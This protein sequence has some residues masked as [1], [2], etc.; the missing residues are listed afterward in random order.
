MIHS[1]PDYLSTALE[2]PPLPKP[3]VSIPSGSVCAMT[4]VRITSGYPISAVTTDATNEYMDTFRG[5]PS[6]YVSEAVAR[7]MK[8]SN[9][10]AG[11][12]I[13]GSHAIFERE[14]GTLESFK[15]LISSAAAKEQGRPCWRDLLV[16]EFHYRIGRRCLILLSTD[17]KK[18]L[19]PR[20]SV[21]VLG[22]H[23]PVYIYDAGYGLAGVRYLS[24]ARILSCLTVIENAYD[25]RF[26]KRGIQTL[27]LNESKAINAIGLSAALEFER[28]LRPI[29]SLPEF[30][31]AL[32]IAQKED[33]EDHD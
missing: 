26:S 15:P 31:F 14:D 28:A 32:L 24:Y 30:L 8:G 3:P 23:T 6:G 27:I 13:N 16:N 22:A 1:A 11:M 9:P 29:R 10:R 18:R 4:G 17:T 7:C 2:L 33:K 5:N 20:A 25:A 12:K 19:W 21:G